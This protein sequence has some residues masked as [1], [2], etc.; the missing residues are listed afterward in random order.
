VITR[1]EGVATYPQLLQTVVDHATFLSAEDRRRYLGENA[2]RDWDL[3]IGAT[4][5]GA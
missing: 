1:R 5:G 2:V 3:S 4:H